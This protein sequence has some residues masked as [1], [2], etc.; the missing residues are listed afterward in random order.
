MK[1][2]AGRVLTAL[3]VL[4][5]IFDGVV[6]FTQVPQVLEANVHLGYTTATIPVIGTIELLCLI[7]YLVPRTA[8]VGAVLLTGYFGGAVASQLRIGEPLFSN[9]LFPIYVAALLW[10]G[11]YLRDARVRAMIMVSQ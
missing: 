11:L 9:V 7:V 8:V 6:K 3:G 4:F 5:M 2:W 10:G 1:L